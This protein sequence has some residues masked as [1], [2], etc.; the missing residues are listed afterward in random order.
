MTAVRL[1]PEM[2]PTDV[3]RNLL[4]LRAS[5]ALSVTTTAADVMDAVAG[6]RGTELDASHV[7]IVLAGGQ[8][9]PLTGQ[10]IRERRAFYF[11]DGGELAAA[12]PD[13]IRTDVQAAA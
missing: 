6:L 5:E 2:T 13:M 12:F 1:P 8:S 9:D 4:L 7:H 3:A 10:T 11:T